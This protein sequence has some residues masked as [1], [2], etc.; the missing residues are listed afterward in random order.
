MVTPDRVTVREKLR[1]DR[2]KTLSSR[3]LP[4]KFHKTG[5]VADT[6]KSP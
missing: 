6:A 3:S 2:N 4:P 5:L 1:G